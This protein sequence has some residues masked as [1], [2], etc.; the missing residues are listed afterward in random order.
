MKWFNNLKIIQKLLSA[1]ILVGLF[2]G[3]VGSIGIYSMRNMNK[4]LE[5][6]YENDLAKI[7]YINELRSSSISGERDLLLVVD[8]GFRPGLD[9]FKKTIE[10]A[11]ASED[12]IIAKYKKILTTD[13]DRK[14]FAEFEKLLA[15]SRVVSDKIIKLERQEIMLIQVD[16]C[17]S[18]G[19][20]F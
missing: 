7:K 9:S 16:L 15:S 20:V 14:E 13:S 4:N 12:E 3:I 1:F 2:I 18:M 6:I 11:K 8:V 17:L 5:N 10:A 19:R